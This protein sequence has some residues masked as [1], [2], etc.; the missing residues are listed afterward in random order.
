MF[1]IHLW[2]LQMRKSPF[3]TGDLWSP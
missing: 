2:V 3:G 1:G